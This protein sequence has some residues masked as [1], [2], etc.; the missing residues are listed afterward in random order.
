M[1]GKP[2]A[3]MGDMTKY[4]G[5]IV[6]GSAGVF[7]GAP[8][9]VACSVCPGGRTSGSPVNPLL[10]AK[11]LPGETDIA[12]P[13]PLPFMLTRAYSSYRTKTPAPSGIFGPGWKAPFDIRLQLRDEELIL[14]D[15]GGRSI[16]FEPLMPGETA[17]SRSESFWLARG[18]V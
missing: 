18:G 6:Q 4:G 15:N 5:P 1:S 7:I 3:R 17:F 2:A 14:N 11:V 10:G 12:L 13:G 8:T 9:G 16:H